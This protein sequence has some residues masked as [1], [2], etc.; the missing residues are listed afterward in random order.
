M[1]AAVGYSLVARGAGGDVANAAVA[2]TYT[3]QKLC[4]LRGAA[5][6]NCRQAFIL[7]RSL[8]GKSQ[9]T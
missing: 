5:L 8:L 4:S 3:T 7:A 9:V 6:F 1:S 2:V